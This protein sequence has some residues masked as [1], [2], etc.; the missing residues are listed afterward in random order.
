MA[1]RVTLETIARASGVSLATVSLVLRDKPGI[2]QETRRRVLSAA[3]QLGYQRKPAEL[4]MPPALQQIGVLIKSRADDP[5]QSNPFYAPVLAGIEASC[6]RQQ[7]N[8][9]YATVP[10]D[11]D[12]YPQELPRLL[13]EDDLDGLLLVGAFVGATIAHL[14]QRRA[15]PTVLVDSYAADN[16]Y[17]SVVS[18]NF[19]GAYQA[20]SYLIR[21]GHQHIGLAG[22][23]PRAYPSIAERRRGYAQA[24]ADHG[25]AEQYF[26]DCHFNQSEAIVSTQALLRRAPQVSAMF[27]TNDYM[28]VAVT[29]AAHELGLRVPEDLSIVGFDDIELAAHVQPPLT[30]MQIDKISMGRMA[31]QLLTNRAEQPAAGGV[32]LMLRPTL[33]ERQ[34]VRALAALASA[35]SG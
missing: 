13:M 30:T 23:L 11:E 3:R 12:N 31:V 5:P 24:L 6:R 33:I 14:M 18:D 10:V 27:C 25:L 17:D 2:H 21:S 20:V 28:A 35:G 22:S 19:R 9:L 32:T 8:M 15:I 26:A 4:L 34:S 16:S 29:Q 1:Q 7:I